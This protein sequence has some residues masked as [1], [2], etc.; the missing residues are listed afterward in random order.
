ME[1][2]QFENVVKTNLNAKIQYINL[3]DILTIEDYYTTD[4][5]WK[6]ENLKDVA[7][8]LVNSMNLN[9]TQLRKKQDSIN[10][11]ANFLNWKENDMYPFY[12]TYYGQSALPLPS[13]TLK[14]ITNEAIENV[15]VRILNETALTNG[16]IEWEDATMYNLKAF[17]GIDPYDIYLSGPKALITLENPNAKT[18]KELILFRD[19]F[20]SSLAPLL[21]NDYAKIT[22]VDLRYISAS[23]VKNIIDFKEGQDVLFLYSTEVLNNGSILKFM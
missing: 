7:E 9:S 21:T 17:N 6:Q 22:V 13:E 10:K 16:S 3:F 8:T 23:L 12:G 4:I 1:Y 15:T 18:Q 14:Y 2:A 11:N 19:S 20:G 5:H